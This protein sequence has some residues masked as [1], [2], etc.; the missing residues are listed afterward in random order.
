MIPITNLPV[1]RTVPVDLLPNPSPNRINSQYGPRPSNRDTWR[2]SFKEPPSARQSVRPR[3]SNR[4][5]R[6]TFDVAWLSLIYQVL[7][8]N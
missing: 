8:S 1:G 2:L 6:C 7:G 4:R 5:R 3:G